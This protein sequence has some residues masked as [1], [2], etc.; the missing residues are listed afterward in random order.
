MDIAVQ[1]TIVFFPHSLQS[2]PHSWFANNFP[3]DKISIILQYQVT[4][5][6]KF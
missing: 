1:G 3:I 6:L 4:D 5:G 2:T